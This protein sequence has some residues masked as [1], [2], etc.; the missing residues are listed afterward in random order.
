M[1]VFLDAL[2]PFWTFGGEVL[3]ALTVF[4]GV[5]LHRARGHLDGISVPTTYRGERLPYSAR[6][7][8]DNIPYIDGMSDS[9]RNPDQAEN[10]HQ[11]TDQ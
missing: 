4:C 2:L 10:Q 1:I 11:A 5:R 8:K 9:H 7:E 3:I 6:G